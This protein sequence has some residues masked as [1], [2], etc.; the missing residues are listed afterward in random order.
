[1]AGEGSVKVFGV[2]GS[3]FSCRVEIALK[4]KG[5]DFEYFEEN[6]A[7]KSPLLLKYNPVYKKVPTFVHNGNP[8]AESLV[9][10]EYID[11]T[12]TNFPL[13]PNNPYQRARARFL[14]KFIDDKCFPSVGKALWARDDK[15]AK[16]NLKFLEN[17][18]NGKKFF[19][20]D[21]VGL[22][23]IAGTCI[24]FWLPAIEEAVGAKLLTAKEFP[25]LCKWSHDYVN[26]PVV[27][28]KLPP[29]DLLIAYFR[30]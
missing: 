24:A 20:G 28:E 16:E 1:M 3:P 11:E 25:K 12:W 9:I 29:R 7:N 21:T 18:L 13:L 5:V 17:E 10:L 19:G 23:D 6:L 14:S 2:Q 26:H 22:V 15:E 30:G 4:L 8:L 27:K